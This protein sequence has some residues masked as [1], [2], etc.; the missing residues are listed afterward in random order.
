[1]SS[2]SSAKHLR[3]MCSV[4]F[5]NPCQQQA[6]YENVFRQYFQIVKTDAVPSCNVNLCEEQNL[7]T[8]SKKSISMVVNNEQFVF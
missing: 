6:C 5:G 3:R 4:C 2:S 1:M 8:E 7:T